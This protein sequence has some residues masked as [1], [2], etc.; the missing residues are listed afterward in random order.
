MSERN[1]NDF[2]NDIT[3][4]ARRTA[5]Y[6]ENLSYKEFMEDIKTQ[7]A[8]IRNL[9]IIGE[10]VKNL[11]EKLRVHILIIQKATANKAFKQIVLSYNRLTY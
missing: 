4:A 9:E 5:S 10:A 3:E 1:D 11:S 2:L 8:V 6:T 7:D